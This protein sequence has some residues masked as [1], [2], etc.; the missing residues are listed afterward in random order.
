MIQETLRNC[1]PKATAGSR[2]NDHATVE[3][4]QRRGHGEVIALSVCLLNRGRETAA[5]S[6]GTHLQRL[7]LGDGFGQKTPRLLLAETIG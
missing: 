5:I 6:V 4:K 1:V 2:H 3:G 7:P